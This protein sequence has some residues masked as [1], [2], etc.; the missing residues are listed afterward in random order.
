MQDDRHN[1]TSSS[2]I[3][4]YGNLTSTKN[5]RREISS[6]VNEFTTEN[7]G[8]GHIIYFFK[9]TIYSTP[10]TIITVFT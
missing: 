9:L 6:N 8:K 2:F 7:N 1:T 3:C 4:T 10:I 5:Q